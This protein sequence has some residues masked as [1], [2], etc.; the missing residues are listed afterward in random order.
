M[1]EFF[2]SVGE[3]LEMLSDSIYNLFSGL[4]SILALIPTAMSTIDYAIAYM[5]AALSAFAVAGIG[6]CVVFHIIG[7]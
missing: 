5:P 7:R 4:L 1:L 3:F 6:V 2:S